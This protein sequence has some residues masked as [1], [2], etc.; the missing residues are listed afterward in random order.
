[1]TFLMFS[2]FIIS[3]LIR[4]YRFSCLKLKRVFFSKIFLYFDWNFKG[5]ISLVVTIQFKFQRE[6][7]SFEDEAKEGL[8]RHN[9]QEW[10]IFSN[11]CE[12]KI[13]SGLPLPALDKS[14][15]NILLFG[16]VRSSRSYNVCLSVPL[17]CCLSSLTLLRSTDG[18]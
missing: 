1:M 9:L 12:R 17:T 14:Y 15:C 2:F 4:I 11:G 6:F 16:S 13:N 7:K 5:F 18:A 8:L 10:I 3:K